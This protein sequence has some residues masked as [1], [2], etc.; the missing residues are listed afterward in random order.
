MRVEKQFL[1]D[2]FRCIGCDTCSVACKM[3]NGLPVGENRLRILNPQQRTVFDKPVGSYP[4][5]KME[6]WPVLEAIALTLKNIGELFNKGLKMNRKTINISSVAVVSNY[7]WNGSKQ[8]DGRRNK[9]LCNAGSNGCQGCL[10]HI[11]QS[12]KGVHDSP[13]SSK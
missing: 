8:T 6:W 12:S 7:C 13:N 9:G 2:I 5:L 4:E 3:E 1:I 10:L 11:G